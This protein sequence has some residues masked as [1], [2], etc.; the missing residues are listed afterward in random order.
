MRQV[1][2]GRPTWQCGRVNSATTPK[3][4]ASRP[5][6]ATEP[7]GTGTLNRGLAVLER[8]AASDAGLTVKELSEGMRIPASATH[9]VLAEL[10]QL[11][12]VRQVEDY[13]RY[14]LTLKLCSLGLAQLSR[15]GVVDVAQPMLERLARESGELARLGIIDGE[16]LVWVA[17]AQG[18]TGGLRFDP[19]MGG[20][21]QLSCT[22]S[23][24]AWLASLSDEQAIGLV[25]RQ[26]GFVPQSSD[27]G[28]NAPRNVAELQRAL[29]HVR[30]RGFA[31][32][33]EAVHSGVAAVAAPVRHAASGEV[34]AVLS[35]AGA[36]VRLTAERMRQLGPVLVQAAREL[37]AAAAAS[38]LL[39][40]ATAT[41]A[42]TP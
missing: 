24:H 22:A 17:K 1:V 9:R 20:V 21:A 12:F 26:G 42:S 28:P 18:A 6:P 31:V 19:D 36:H 35:I 41:V 3:G 32:L 5:A 38:P 16:S 7:V 23:G 34:I 2:F 30:E 11:G 29:A 39:R 4:A 40:R 15:A 14:A 25:T 8:L 13:G 33:A 37:S 10:V 27:A